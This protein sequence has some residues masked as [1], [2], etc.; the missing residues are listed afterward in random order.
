[1]EANHE[2]IP[3]SGDEK[4]INARKL[5]NNLLSLEMKG[6]K[7]STCGR[8]RKYKMMMVTALTLTT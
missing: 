5:C 7:V 8:E 1:M 4:K 2:V 3:T 6:Q